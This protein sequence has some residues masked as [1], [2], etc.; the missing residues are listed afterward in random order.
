M[1]HANLREV[2]Q[3]LG[4]AAEATT[5]E[6]LGRAVMASAVALVGADSAVVTRIGTLVGPVGM[7]GPVGPAG[8]WPDGFVTVEQQLAFERL[9]AADPW[10]LATRTR[11]GGG[12]PLQI[13]DLFSRTAYRRLDIYN[14]L[15]R[16]LD[17]EHQV[18]FSIP[19]GVDQRLCVAL[20]RRDREFSTDEM[21]GLT[22][23]RRPLTA[24]A[25]HVGGQGRSGAL[26]LSR[27]QSDV[28]SL[29]AS[30]LGNDQIGRRLGISTRTVHKHL[31]HIYANIGVT[32]RTQATARWFGAHRGERDHGATFR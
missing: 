25:A 6:E 30:G 13:S 14:E 17:V 21:D 29:V 8:T 9:N 4:A 27:R 19:V 18:A 24:G 11:V 12:E 31:E 3:S 28:L 23:L 15:F 5:V 7:V 26:D 1:L 16:Y 32:N 20:D 22:A 10:P 2:L